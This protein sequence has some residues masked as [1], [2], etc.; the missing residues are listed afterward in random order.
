MAK[1]IVSTVAPS[2]FDKYGIHFPADW[3]IKF[4]DV[5]YT[6]EQLIEAL[7]DREYL[8]VGAVHPVS[9]EVIKANPS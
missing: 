6:D 5:P 3:D 9:A 7:K 2:R 4:V 1:K 8:F